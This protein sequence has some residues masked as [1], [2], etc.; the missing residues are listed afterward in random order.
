M[1]KYDKYANGR[2]T[3]T[4]HG[5]QRIFTPRHVTRVKCSL[6]TIAAG[7]SILIILVLSVFPYAMDY[8]LGV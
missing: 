3:Y 5:A 1:N 7:I 6:W 2:V 8:L 4:Q